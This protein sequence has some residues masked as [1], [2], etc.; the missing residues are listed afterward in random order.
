MSMVYAGAGIKGGQVI[1][2]TD[3]TASEPI[4]SPYSPDD[5]AASFYRAIGIDHQKE[6]HTPDGRPVMIVGK[7]NPIRE[8]WG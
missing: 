4:D 3:K 2:A 8:L 5:A 7:G 6:Y 1:G